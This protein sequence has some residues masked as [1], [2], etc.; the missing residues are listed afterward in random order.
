MQVDG[1]IDLTIAGNS[2]DIPNYSLNKAEVL[3]RAEK[4]K[5]YRKQLVGDKLEKYRADAR[6]R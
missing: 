5:G 3:S 2:F 1:C 6:E 4:A